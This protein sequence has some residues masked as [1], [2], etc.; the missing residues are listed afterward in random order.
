MSDSGS[1]SVTSS[2]ESDL[3]RRGSLQH[4]ETN[5]GEVANNT[6]NTEEKKEEEEHIPDNRAVSVSD[7]LSSSMKDAEDEILHLEWQHDQNSD[8]S[9]HEVRLI[10]FVIIPGVYGNSETPR[11]VENPGSGS[12]S[13]VTEF[14]KG[15]CD[16]ITGPRAPEDSCR[17]LRFSYESNELFSDHRSA[18]AIHRIALRLLNSLR[19][20]RRDE[21]KVRI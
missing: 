20:K 11:Q 14:A 5:E 1:D 13:W 15:T 3:S 9:N 6:E 12:T 4:G 2:N 17:V 8:V 19:L 16:E 10:D 21:E 18:D 7:R